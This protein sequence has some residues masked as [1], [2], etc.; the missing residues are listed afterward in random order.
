MTATP[1]P[2]TLA[3]TLYGD[4]DLTVLD[5]MPSGR[6]PIQT[7]IIT[8]SRRDHAYEKM[9]SLI[10]E[11]R[12]AYV[13]CP[14]IDEPDETKA[15][16]L[17]ARS[18]ASEMKRLSTKVFPEFTIAKLHSKM[19]PK[20]KEETMAKFEKGEINILISTS[21]V[22]VGVNVPNA[23]VIMIEGS[24]RFGLAQLHQLRGRVMRSKPTRYR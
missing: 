24:E 15:L 2:R 11:G 13:I 5:E 4:L 19:T 23:T 16:A 12:Q 8:P 9:R 3:L 20:E 14:R 18:V 1:I 6:K 22:E 21:V 10:K 17:Q 7:D